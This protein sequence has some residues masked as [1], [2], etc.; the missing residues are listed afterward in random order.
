MDLSE[1]ESDSS[2]AMDVVTSDDSPHVIPIGN[3]GLP[4]SGLFE[5]GPFKSLF[6]DPLSV[7]MLDDLETDSDPE[8]ISDFSGQV[9]VSSS[10]P[11]LGLSS[12]HYTAASF[13]DVLD[14]WLA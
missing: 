1:G 4:K 10:L 12:G 5:S 14:E 9:Q 13:A 7:V 2:N 3:L 6:L 8:D 11:R